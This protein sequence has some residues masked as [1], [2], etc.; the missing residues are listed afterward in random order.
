[1]KSGV[2]GWTCKEKTGG[3]A[4]LEDTT[5]TNGHTREAALRGIAEK[6]PPRKQ[7]K[8]KRSIKTL[9]QKPSSAYRNARGRTGGSQAEH[10]PPQ[11]QHRI[12]D[13]W[14]LFNRETA[15]SRSNPLSAAYQEVRRSSKSPTSGNKTSRESKMDKV[16]ETLLDTTLSKGSTLDGS[17]GGCLHEGSTQLRREVANSHLI[18]EGHANQH[19]NPNNKRRRTGQRGPKVQRKQIPKR[20]M[21][22]GFVA[23]PHD[24]TRINNQTNDRHLIQTRISYTQLKTSH[25]LLEG[26]KVKEKVKPPQTSEHINN[27]LKQLYHCGTESAISSQV[28]RQLYFP[29]ERG[30]NNPCFRT[31]KHRRG[32]DGT[33]EGANVHGP[34]SPQVRGEKGETGKRLQQA[35]K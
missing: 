12:C 1:M 24:H 8:T 31:R 16:C 19:S 14:A 21:G 9:S 33:S 13:R 25:F 2:P 10:S 32:S 27:C 4:T 7:L 18:K 30:K 26:E 3:Y 35:V 34:E 11:Q 29:Q 17:P 22:M 6:I 20:R 28:I 5:N 23:K 15:S